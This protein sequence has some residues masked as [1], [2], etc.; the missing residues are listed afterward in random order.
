MTA[1]KYQRIKPLLAAILVCVLGSLFAPIGSVMLTLMGLTVFLGVAVR[2]L[3]MD[4]SK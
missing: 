4:F 3:V 1:R 2:V